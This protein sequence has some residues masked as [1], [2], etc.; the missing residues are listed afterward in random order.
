MKKILALT[1]LLVVFVASTSMAQFSWQ[2]YDFGTGP[3]DHNNNWSPIDYPYGID[4]LPSPGYLGEGGE[5]FD[6]EGFNYALDGQTVHLSLTNSFGYS[7]YSSGWDNNY[8]L[9]DI[10]FGFNGEYYEYAIDVTDGTLWSVDTYVGIPQTDGSYYGT[11]IADQ[12]GAWEIGTGTILGNVTTTMTWFDD[13]ETNPMQGDGDTYV[14]EF[15]FDAGMDA[16][17]LTAFSSYNSVGFHNILGCGN[18]MVEE[19]YSGVP[20]P[21]TLILMGFGLVGLGTYY[22]KRK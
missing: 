15:A 3:F 9:G 17:L 2:M 20:E 16:D 8:D 6:L 12:V 11:S 4:N 14:W 21:A 7:A 13:L 1:L 18:D 5:G 19:T 10:F 22:R